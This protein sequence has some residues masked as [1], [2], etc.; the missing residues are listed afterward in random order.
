MTTT[1]NLPAEFTDHT[2]ARGMNEWTVPIPS[3]EDRVLIHEDQLLDSVS[4][5]VGGLVIE[6][7]CGKAIIR[8]ALDTEF[9]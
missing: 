3:Y 5:Y 1:I 7:R 4:V 6:M 2:R 9:V 8:R